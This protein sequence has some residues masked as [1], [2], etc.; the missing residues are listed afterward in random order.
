MN[1]LILVVDDEP[2]YRLVLS[3]MLSALDY[4]VLT[5]GSGE[6]AY[7]VFEERPRTDV[8]LTDMTMPGGSGIELLERVKALRPEVPVIML[9][10]HGTVEL[11]VKAMKEGAFDY[12][13]KPYK[14]EELTRTVAKAMDLSRLGRQ[15]RELKNQLMEKH[16]FGSLIGKS[17]AMLELY[18][19][20][21]KVAPTRANV[22]ITGESGTGKELV[23][24]AVH[25]NSPRKNHT[26]V[27]VNCSAL[28]S[29]LL[30]S[31]LFGHVKGAFTGAES[32]RQGRFELADRGTL[33]LDE[34]GEMGQNAQ[35]KLLRALQERTI[36]RVGAGTPIKVDVRLISATN[37]D[38]KAEVAAGRFRDDLFYRLNVVHIPLPPL[39]ERL[40][41]LPL[42][43]EHFLA[44]YAEEGK[45]P[46][47]VHAETMRLLFE[48]SWP[49]NVRELEN[50]IE[51]GLV[52]SARNV[53][54]PEDLPEEFLRTGA[55]GK[56]PIGGRGGPS[57]LPRGESGRGPADGDHLGTGTRPEGFPAGEGLEGGLPGRERSSEERAAG[58]LNGVGHAAGEPE[59]LKKLLLSFPV[60]TLTLNQALFAMEE[61]LL[62]RA[63]DQENGV[64]ARAADR[65]GMKRN[66]FKYKWDKYAGSP[67]GPE[68]EILAAIVPPDLSL[69]DAQELLEERLLSASLEKCGGVQARAAALLDIKRN[70]FLYKLR[71]Y[72]RL[73]SWLSE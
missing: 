18:A 51:R 72:P 52:L 12:L 14:N 41:D 27:A 48:Y 53:I 38:L 26:F 6:E 68:A 10:A 65:L 73:S 34:V 17:K 29:N 58:T 50:V 37:K 20:L 7:R 11:A 33:F 49:G 59:W 21:E 69:F 55:S 54:R 13:T 31:E 30:E 44:K 47:R 67:P 43:A 28:S 60:G 64:Q 61:G 66:V 23:A 42:L 22:L 71:K 4:E 1:G 5:A 15:N 63:M 24:R 39:R 19:L 2:G 32:G 8:I 3:E 25:Y 9:T 62:R 40:D 56:T 57:S 45:E 70:T 16:S 46:P 36:E 35:V